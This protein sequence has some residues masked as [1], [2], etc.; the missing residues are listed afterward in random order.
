MPADPVQQIDTS[1][2]PV[3]HCSRVRG[4]DQWTGPGND[5]AARFGRDGAQRSR[6]ADTS[7]GG[8]LIS[9]ERFAVR[10]DHHQ[11][12][13]QQA[14]SATITRSSAPSEAGQHEVTGQALITAMAGRSV[15]RAD[16]RPPPAAAGCGK[17]AVR[18]IVCSRRIPSAICHVDC[19]V[20]LQRLYCLL[21]MDVSSRYVHI[22]SVTAN[23]GTA[24]TLGQ[25]TDFEIAL[26]CRCET[27][28]THDSG[29]PVIRGLH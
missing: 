8:R 5:L 17:R 18:R 24:T 26:T 19:A 23:P 22:L 4:P 10:P 11:D 2:L 3:K 16:G 9:K 6:S 15:R 27:Q 13:S 1:V 25:L 21:A 7:A 28:T 29:I 12:R 14:S 20:T